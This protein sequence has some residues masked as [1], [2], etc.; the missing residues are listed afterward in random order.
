MPRHFRI[1][2][3]LTLLAGASSWLGAAQGA[4]AKSVTIDLISTQGVGAPIGT[5]DLED[6]PGGLM[7]K[8]NLKGLP[9]GAHGFHLHTNASCAAAKK[10]GQMVAGLGAGGHFDP[11]KTNKHLGPDAMGG[12]KGDLP[13]LQVA[14]DG[15]ATGSLMAPHLTL[16]DVT[17][18]SL[19]IHAGGDNYADLPKPLG[20]G[21]IRIACGVVQ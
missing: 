2:S 10:D 3:C 11:A 8:P 4:D 19:M 13:V 17:G 5:I 16:A 1:I 18:H 6:S 14:A 20:G 12:H 9:P 15:T 21:G 7:L